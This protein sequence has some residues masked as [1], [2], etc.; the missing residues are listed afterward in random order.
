MPK[1]KETKPRNRNQKG[2]KGNRNDK[3]SNKITKNTADRFRPYTP[4]KVEETPL[5]IEELSKLLNEQTEKIGTEIETFYFESLTNVESQHQV[6]IGLG[7]EISNDLR[8][9]YGAL[10]SIWGDSFHKC[11]TSGNSQEIFDFIKDKH[12]EKY[13]GPTKKHS[14]IF[15]HTFLEKTM[16]LICNEN[17]I[18]S[19][20]I[21][22]TLKTIENNKT[23]INKDII[24]KVATKCS[25]INS[26]KW[27][28]VQTAA[29]EILGGN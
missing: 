4:P 28:A 24:N 15:L 11:V 13:L 23:D 20:W 22:L 17:E 2:G 10:H 3:N 26:Q 9:M 5:T 18:L 16:N 25:S 7:N 12:A 29:K 14:Q 6:V 21:L 27:E 1:N 19:D 8:S